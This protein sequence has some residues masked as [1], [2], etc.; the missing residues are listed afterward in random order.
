MKIK[1]YV[2]TV[3]I[4][5]LV[6]IIITLLSREKPDTKL[7]IINSLKTAQEY[8]KDGNVSLAEYQ[9]KYILEIDPA[10]TDALNNLANMY[11]KQKDYEKAVDLYTRILQTDT[12]YTLAYYN[13]GILLLARGD[14]TEAYEYLNTFVA[15][16]DKANE[17]SN[18]VNYLL[19]EKTIL[20]W[21]K[22]WEDA[23]ASDDITRYSA[24]YSSEFQSPTG[25]AGGNNWNYDSWMRDQQ[26]KSIRR[27]SLDIQIKNLKITITGESATAKFC[28]IFTSDVYNDIGSKTLRL[29]YQN[30]KW[31]IVFEYW[32][33]SDC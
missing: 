21:A 14:S 7:E 2:S 19:V 27:N 10:N 26:N 4:I 23:S 32:E 28:Q 9:Y 5:I 20:D 13:L 33:L 11:Q 6:G 3:V 29:K 31:L 25:K 17:L 30:M 24:F 22:A 12:S 15:K 8:E 18:K 1:G 16:S